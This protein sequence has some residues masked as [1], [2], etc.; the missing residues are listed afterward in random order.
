MGASAGEGAH[1]E[2]EHSGDH[3]PV[4]GERVQRPVG[5]EDR[6]EGAD[7]RAAARD[8][9]ADHV[10]GP[11]GDPR[12]DMHRERDRV[13]RRRRHRHR[14]RA[15]LPALLRPP[16]RAPLGAQQPLLRRQQ[17]P[18]PLGP[19]RRHE[20]RTR[21]FSPPALP[22]QLRSPSST[23]FFLLTAC[24]KWRGCNFGDVDRNTRQPS[25]CFGNPLPFRA[26]NSGKGRET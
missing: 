10:G 11:Q 18:A 9:A 4:P 7:V 21:A 20:P 22:L 25:K 6:R 26:T 14:L 16:G 1:R 8:A 3:R 15:A 2:R 12:G 17:H 24:Y 23:H 13:G 5:V 19:V